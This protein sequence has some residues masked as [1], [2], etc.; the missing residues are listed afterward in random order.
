MD[1]SQVQIPQSFFDGLSQILLGLI[2]EQLVY[3]VLGSIVATQAA[4]WLMTY[5]HKTPDR[6]FIMFVMAPL[7]TLPISIATWTHGDRVPSWVVAIVASLLANLVF[8][9]FVKKLIGN[10]APDAYDRMNFP[11]DRRK[12]DLPPP[13]EG[14]R[15]QP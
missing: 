14:D 13:A 8:F 2:N 12:S 6:L 11:V 9:I 15:R 3:I 7:V 4:K 5:A 10:F 1:G